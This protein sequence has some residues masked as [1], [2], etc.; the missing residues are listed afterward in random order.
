M[1]GTRIL[2][3]S[4]LAGLLACTPDDQTPYELDPTAE[5]EKEVDSSGGMISTPA[6]L[7]L[8]IPDGALDTTTN[9]TVAPTSGTG[10][11]SGVNGNI[12][13]GT[14]FDITP[15][16]LALTT[17]AK[18]E[19]SAAGASN[20]AQTSVIAGGSGVLQNRIALAESSDPLSNLGYFI[21][22]DAGSGKVE[23]SPRINFD[24]DRKV[25]SGWINTL[26]T[27]AVGRTT[28]LGLQ[29]SFQ[30]TATGGTIQSG[31]YQFKCGLLEATP[32]VGAAD[33]STV[34]LYVDE[35]VIDRYP[36]I[37]AVITSAHGTLNVDS[38]TGTVSGSAVIHGVI[39]AVVGGTVT[40]KEVTIEVVSG[41]GGT[42][43]TP[44]AVPYQTS[45]NQISFQTAKGWE[46]F[47]Y[48]ATATY[49]EFSLSETTIPLTDEDGVE[50]E[51][52]IS[53][54]VRLQKSTGV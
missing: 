27:V 10:L 16:G 11:G 26:G 47:N 39:Q 20:G 14:A 33:G 6:G 15:K 54:I 3:A 8:D 43:G 49:L 17:P 23:V 29:P 5:V 25:I 42:I 53:L 38:Q 35:S 36:R 2:A 12:I 13:A 48:T 34:G 19:L 50:R 24:F 52:P 44:G 40:S 21:Y 18:I 30:Y 45:R 7:S 46:T 51:Y 28:P 41:Q 32:C 22:V 1:S 4:L 31:S 37:G 9:V